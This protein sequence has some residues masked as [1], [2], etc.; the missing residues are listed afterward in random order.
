MQHKKDGKEMLA[1]IKELRDPKTNACAISACL[2]LKNCSYDVE[3]SIAVNLTEFERV[4]SRYNSCGEML[5]ERMK[6]DIF[7]HVLPNVVLLKIKVH[8]GTADSSKHTVALH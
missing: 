5:S 7:V 6:R 4:G 2:D 8:L 1:C 3:K